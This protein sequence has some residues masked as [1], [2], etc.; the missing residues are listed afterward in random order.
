MKLWIKNTRGEPSASLTFVSVAFAV[1]VVHMILSMFVNPFGIAIV[2]FNASEAMM[3]LSPLLATYWGR[4]KTD[5]D[6][7][8]VNSKNKTTVNENE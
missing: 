1:I 2:P 7:K 8:V 6:E 5:V 3:V 4:R